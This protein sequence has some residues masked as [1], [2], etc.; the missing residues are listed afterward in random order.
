MKLS[1]ALEQELALLNDRFPWLKNLRMSPYTTLHAGRVTS[2]LEQDPPVQQ[3]LHILQPAGK[4]LSPW[5][6]LAVATWATRKAHLETTGYEGYKRGDK[7]K[8]TVN[9]RSIKAKFQDAQANG[10]LTFTLLA[11]GGNQEEVEQSIRIDPRLVVQ[12]TFENPS[13]QASVRNILRELR[14]QES[15]LDKLLALERPTY[16][17]ADLTNRRTLQTLG[18]TRTGTMECLGSAGIEH[19]SFTTLLALDRALNFSHEGFNGLHE[20][21]NRL[22]ELKIKLQCDVLQPMVY[23]N[24]LEEEDVLTLTK[25]LDWV[26]LDER[27]QELEN[28]INVSELETAQKDEL[29]RRINQ[30][31][32]TIPADDSSSPATAACVLACGYG[33]LLQP[34]L[35]FVDLIRIGGRVV[36]VGSFDKLV[37]SLRTAAPSDDLARKATMVNTMQTRWNDLLP[38]PDP[39]KHDAYQDH[40]VVSVVGRN[41]LD[42]QLISVG[43]E[44]P[45]QALSILRARLWDIL[46]DHIQ[47]ADLKAVASNHLEPVM[48]YLLYTPGKI[49][50]ET[51]SWVNR[52]LEQA[53][54]LLNDIEALRHLPEIR[55]FL[56]EL[57]EHSNMAVTA[58]NALG[59]NQLKGHYLPPEAGLLICSEQDPPHDTELPTITIGNANEEVQHVAITGWIAKPFKTWLY[60]M[61]AAPTVRKITIIDAPEQIERWHLAIRHRQYIDRRQGRWD[62]RFAALVPSQADDNIN[63]EVVQ[64]QPSRH[65]DLSD[66]ELINA[67]NKEFRALKPR[68]SGQG[69]EGDMRHMVPSRMLEFQDGRYMAYASEG[70]KPIPVL[71]GMKGGPVHVD[72][73]NLRDVRNGDRVLWLEALLANLRRDV[74]ESITHAEV[75]ALDS[76]RIALERLLTEHYNDDYDLLAQALGRDRQ[77]IVRWLHD[78][79]LYTPNDPGPKQILELAKEQGFFA[80]SPPLDKVVQRIRN[81]KKLAMAKRK[82]LEQLLVESLSKNINLNM[83]HGEFT[84]RNIQYRYEI[85]TVLNNYTDMEPLPIHHLYRIEG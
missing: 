82:S 12:A 27:C 65:T 58:I 76:W 54:T 18:M 56:D 10:K 64:H 30:I 13:K 48:R 22:N 70:R 32:T 21:A 9:R 72:M 34:G 57:V 46:C 47:N 1:D 24:V 17:R 36:I 14:S 19:E 75:Q 20:D 83:V 35:G 42:I 73:V 55:T 37:E 29:R 31:R 51:Q 84:H 11:D 69:A 59:V 81:A 79:D 78:E 68:I 50:D 2:W 67:L 52:H 7:I 60:G 53:R 8:I 26:G 3:A 74:R 41:K 16:G 63:V 39:A 49:T 44:Y 28:G 25:E 40:E 23:N 4:L 5:I 38:E 15:M 62:D 71:T 77:T 45:T 80:E 66:D 85:L 6:G 61:I 33:D 43:Q